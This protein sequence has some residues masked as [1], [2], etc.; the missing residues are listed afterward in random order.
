MYTWLR[1]GLFLLPPEMAHDVALNALSAGRFVGLPRLVGGC[2]RSAPVELM[3]LSFPNPVG[4]AAGLDKN[5]D[6]IY[7]LGQLGF[8]FVEVGTV[9]PRPQPGNPKPRMFRLPEHQALINRLGFNNK[10]VDHLVDR[11]KSTRY[12]GIIGANIGKQKDTPVDEAA[13]DY[14]FCLEKVHPHCHYITVNI[15]SPNTANLRELQDTGHLREFL[16]ELVRARN[17][18]DESNETC[19]PLLIKIA[20]DWEPAALTASLEVI[21]TSGIDGLITTNTTL[22]RTRVAGHA[23]ADEAG[24]LSGAPV[25]SLADATLRR[26][27]EVLGTDFP[28]IGLGG[29]TRGEDA[30]DK[31]RCGA[32]L[33]QIYTGFIYQGPRLVHDCIR[34]WQTVDEDTAA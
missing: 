27:R 19:R 28:I 4:L 16:D 26:A 1:N 2:P 14:R 10:G 24:G 29:I 25:K 7:A 33:V 34:A 18:L 13:A 32:D 6:H 11:L 8:G 9:T 12:D 21:A 5:G 20:P 23:H 3:G 30:A 31:R 22:D 15:S 17:S